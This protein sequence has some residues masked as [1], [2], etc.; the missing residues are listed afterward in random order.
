M[1]G[2]DAFRPKILKEIV[3]TLETQ[4]THGI[5]DQH[6]LEAAVRDR[7]ETLAS[8]LTGHRLER[9]L[10]AD[11]R[12]QRLIPCAQR[13]QSDRLRAGYVTEGME[14]LNDTMDY[15]AALGTRF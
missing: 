7:L 6:S 14:M 5:T 15:A 8:G 2:G 11:L 13:H 12:R 9:W 3:L 1:K 10:L 4:V